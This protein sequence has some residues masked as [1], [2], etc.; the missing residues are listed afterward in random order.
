L[1]PSF[2]YIRLCLSFSVFVSNL[3][4]IFG[5][6]LFWSKDQLDCGEIWTQECFE[7]ICW[8]AGLH[9]T[10]PLT[11]SYLRNKSYVKR[12]GKTNFESAIKF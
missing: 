10:T 8:T 11:G 12:W 4:E 5:L 2:H 9:A 6:S 3:N 1:I 7:I